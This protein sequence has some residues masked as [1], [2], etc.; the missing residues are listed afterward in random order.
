MSI[1]SPDWLVYNASMVDGKKRMRRILTVSLFFLW[2]VP[3][4][5]GTG[6]RAASGEVYILRVSGT[7][8]PVIA[9][10]IDRGID[11]AE[12]Q[13]ATAIVIVLDTPGGLLDATK[14]IV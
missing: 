5:L 11:R 7:I 1:A 4:V 6:V 2:L 8:V 10:Y 14:T 12:E 13:Q 9:D 3:A